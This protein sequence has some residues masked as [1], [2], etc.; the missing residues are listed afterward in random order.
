MIQLVVLAVLSQACQANCF[1]QYFQTENRIQ[2][3][4]MH[5]LLCKII[6]LTIK[7]QVKY[8]TEILCNILHR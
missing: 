6:F 2:T 7:E 4:F 3:Q 5:F 1:G 8:I